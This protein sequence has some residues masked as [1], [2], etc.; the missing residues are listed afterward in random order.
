M[1]PKEKAKQLVNKFNIDLQPFSEYGS[2]D[3]DVAKN[4]ALFAVDEIL[5]L[6]VHECSMDE[7]YIRHWQQV[8]TE[9][10]LL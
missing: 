2:W 7:G 9:I 10:E 4:M 1:T 3:I 8:K 5:N 6:N